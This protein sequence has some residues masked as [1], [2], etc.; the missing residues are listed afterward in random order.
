MALF[1]LGVGLPFRRIDPLQP[2]LP[3]LLGVKL[4]VHPL[5]VYLLLTWVGGFDRIWVQTA[6]LM[7]A[8]PTS[9][10]VLMLAKDH[11]ASVDRVASVVLLATAVSIATVTVVLILL[12][13]NLPVR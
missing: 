5:I 4:I 1:A 9:A 13:N 11:R 6:V 10:D 2:E 7:A 8:L 12:V 3:L